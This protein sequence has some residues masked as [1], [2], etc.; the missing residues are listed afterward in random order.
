MSLLLTRVTPRCW[1]C[2]L[3]LPLSGSDTCR[4]ISEASHICSRNGKHQSD[5]PSSRDGSWGER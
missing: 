5:P 4:C 1:L 2:H 3:P